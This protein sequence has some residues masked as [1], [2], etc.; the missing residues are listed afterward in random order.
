V[1][2]ARIPLHTPLFRG[3]RRLRIALVGLPGG[4]KTTLFEAVSS[5]APK[6]GEA[7]RHA[8]VYRECTVQIG[9]TKPAWST[10]RHPLLAPS[11]RRRPDALKYLLW[12]DDRPVVSACTNARGPPAPFAPPDLIIQ[13]VD[14]TNLQS[15][16]ELTLEL[17]QLGRPIVLALNQMDEALKKGLHVNTRALEKLLGMPVVPTV[18]L[19]GQ[20]ISRLCS[21][22]RRRR[23][24]GDLSAA[25]AAQQAY[26]G[27]PA[28]T[29][30]G[31]E[32]PRNPCRVP[33][34]ASPAAEQFAAD[35]GFIEE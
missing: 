25:A 3:E 10:C 15:H 4:G 14:A 24:R 22:G 18:A 33:R 28:A 34:A 30:G 5:T 12:G 26:R 29:F 7:D 35:D 1:T 23:A 16:L 6:R 2:E 31:H 20:G 27:E 13:V 21:N 9:S 11:R 19:M 8:P 17:S 32:P